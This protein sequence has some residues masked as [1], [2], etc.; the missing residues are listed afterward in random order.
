MDKIIQSLYNRKSVREFTNQDVAPQIKEELLKATV[1]APTAGN[2]MMYSIIDVT[3]PR[4]KEQLAKSCDNQPFIAT[5]PL[6]FIFVADH[7][8]WHRS[9]NIAGANPREI[10]VGD[11]FLSITDTAIAAQNMVVAA[12]AMG[13][14]SCYIGDIL[15][16]CEL[17]RELLNLPEKSVPVCMLVIGYPTEKQK[18]RTKPARFDIKYIVG[19]NSYP[20]L[21]DV[22]LISCY[23]DRENSTKSFDE[24]MK[25]FCKRKFNSEF[26][27]EMNRSV[28]EYLKAYHKPCNKVFVYGTLMKGHYNHDYY[29]A[30]ATYLG[31]RV[32]DGY[33]LYDLGA[34]PG[35]VAR[36]GE[37]VRGEL[38][39]IEE[40]MLADLDIL[41]GE[42]TLYNRLTVEVE[43]EQNLTKE[44]AY[45]YI[46]NNDITRYT[47]IPFCDQPWRKASRQNRFEEN[48]FEEEEYVWYASYGSNILYERFLYYIKGGKFNNREYLGC[49][50]TQLPLEDEPILIPY[51]LYFGN[52]SPTWGGS[53]VAFLDVEVSGITMGRMYLITR[54][55]FE[56][57]W[58]QEGN[59]KNW[60][61]KVV[62][63][64]EKDGIEI[65]TFTNETRRPANPPSETYL[66]II[67]KGIAEIY[68]DIN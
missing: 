17:H 10:G 62:C 51:Q 22:E 8:R 59:Y 52:S 28:E 32:L 14:G 56:D 29:L 16:Q 67:K 57:I 18:N 63:L 34:Y 12:E 5:A 49:E 58:E 50:N 3:D 33:E 21:S 40:D 64:G 26:S 15:E 19:E 68:P 55:Q 54:D 61:N 23:T 45:V 9:F 30:K 43:D 35:I 41:E 53:G 36:K 65:L 2:Q 6:V 42:G 1:Q 48:Y 39:Q 60:Y 38:Y 44:R 47:K 7:T 13:L 46:Y 31:E 66:E 24:Y 11:L 37:K 27:M 25:A 4:L 20:H